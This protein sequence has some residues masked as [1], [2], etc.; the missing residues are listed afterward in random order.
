[1]SHERQRRHLRE[2][3]GNRRSLHLRLLTRTWYNLR[4]HFLIVCTY[5][6][7]LLL[8]LRLKLTVT[9]STALASVAVD[10]RLKLGRCAQVFLFAFVWIQILHVSVK[11]RQ[12]WVGE[13]QKITDLSATILAT[14]QK[15]KVHNFERWIYD[16][17]NILELF[18]R[19]KRNRQTFTHLHKI[20]I[21]RNLGKIPFHKCLLTNSFLYCLNIQLIDENWKFVFDSMSIVC[22][23]R[24]N[25]M[26]EIQIKNL[27]LS[28]EKVI[29]QQNPKDR[30]K[31]H[32]ISF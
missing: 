4:S 6:L 12:S 25:K 3:A 9:C 21:I 2:T 10:C 15:W 24:W 7:Q 29:S 20:N 13:K 31:E 11:G 8:H 23:V 30:T 17:R 18:F 16:F 5:H 28:L 26:F 22:L 1:M 14:I 32:E 19:W 27:L